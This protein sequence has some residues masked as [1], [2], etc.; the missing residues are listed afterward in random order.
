MNFRILIGL[1]IAFALVGC[2]NNDNNPSNTITHIAVKLK[3][4]NY[5]SM[6]DAKGNLA[7]ESEI[8]A[9]DISPVVE[10]CFVITDN[11]NK[12]VVYK[13]DKYPEVIGNLKGLLQVGTMTEGVI[14]VVRQGS[15]IEYYNANGEHK[16]TLDPIN[17][18][19][20]VEVCGHFS[21]GVT[22]FVTESGK[23]GVIDN[24]GNIVI[25]PDKFAQIEPFS[26]GYAIAKLLTDDTENPTWA[27]ID[28]NGE[29]V[30]K[31]PKSA[32]FVGRYKHNRI[33][34]QYNERSYMYDIDGNKTALP[35]KVSSIYDWN[36]KYISFHND[37]YKM[38]VINYDGETVIRSNY[39]RIQLL[40]NELFL[41]SE[42][43]K[44]PKIINADNEVV[45]TLKS[46]YANY[47]PDLFD[48]DFGLCLS[49]EDSERS[50]LVTFEG[51]PINKDLAI[52][53]VG[54]CYIYNSVFADY[55]NV[56]EAAKTFANRIT[57]N[58]INDIE[59][60]TYARALENDFAISLYSETSY[61]NSWAVS[62]RMYYISDSYLF[63]KT[64]GWYDDAKIWACHTEISLPYHNLYPKVKDAIVKE[65][66]KNG[67]NV[68]ENKDAYAVLS[69]NNTCCYLYY[70]DAE[71]NIQVYIFNKE[72]EAEN[73]YYLLDKAT[74]AYDNIKSE[75]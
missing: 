12:K 20:I 72:N 45:V 36:E 57:E 28:H 17:G 34:A 58:G 8:D 38:S 64:A 1:A 2:S 47:I 67:F 62:K 52:E 42:F 73:R 24:N 35:R 9:T 60:G 6:I 4:E 18:D 74:T 61:Q 22:S 49:D 14:P 21:E 16:F 27:L 48:N 66:H 15:R 5:W 43:E 11:T 3:G 37:N 54:Y 30:I 75:L 33:A 19:E 46:D 39:D 53:Q 25:E 41:A 65:I 10:N 44:R 26:N 70:D 7:F 68:D 23:A 55:Y 29:I 13:L 32:Y 40:P 31:L 59:I 50:T 63:D 51:E 56:E 71:N 69:L